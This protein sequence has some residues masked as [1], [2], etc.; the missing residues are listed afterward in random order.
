VP[1]SA[2]RSSTFAWITKEEDRD[3]IIDGVISGVES[4]FVT[5]WGEVSPIKRAA[6]GYLRHFPALKDITCSWGRGD[7]AVP[8]FIPPSLEALSLWC[9]SSTKPV[10]L[11][12]SLPPIIKSS[13]AKL[14]RLN[15]SSLSISTRDDGD[16]LRGV[17]GLL[18]ACAPTLQEVTLSIYHVLFESAVEVVE[19]LASCQHLKRLTA[20]INT[21]AVMPPGRGITL[22]LARLHL[23]RGSSTGALSSNALW[24]LMARGGLPILSC[25]QLKPGGWAWDAELGPA[26]VAAFK[27]VAGTLK[28]LVL[29]HFYTADAEGGGLSQLGRAI[30]RLRRLE[31]LELNLGKHGVA[32]HHV[33]RGMGEG[34]CPALRSL[35]IA[36]ERE[37]SWLACRPSIIRPS[38]HALRVKFRN[39]DGRNQDGAEP[40]AVACALTTLGYRGSVVM[41]A[42]GGEV[43]RHREEVREI[44]RPRAHVRFS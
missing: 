10:L 1:A 23:S 41:A 13:G 27:G 6:L 30:G 2:R 34:S 12:G 43:V 28:E 40:L 26:L 36:I 31:S 19:G 18:Q 22:R 21:L 24:E 33:A 5:C 17:R 44:L 16:L 20:P 39:S 37:A 29:H 42:V 11:L 15:L 14:R 38:V 3:L 32:Y 9:S 7:S 8:P 4:I 35:T 25:L